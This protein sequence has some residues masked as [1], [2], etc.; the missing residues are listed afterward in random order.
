MK[1]VNTYT[2]FAQPTAIGWLPTI[3]GTIQ[4]VR[5]VIW[6][7]PHGERVIHDAVAK[8][9]A[10]HKQPL[11]KPL[12]EVLN[13]IARIVSEGEATT[14]PCTSAKE[15]LGL[16]AV[17]MQFTMYLPSIKCYFR[18]DYR[19]IEVLYQAITTQGAK[20]P[21]GLDDQLR[22]ALKI[23][24]TL[25]EALW[26]LLTASRLYARWYDGEAFTHFPAVSQ[27]KAKRLMSTWSTA[28]AAL[29]PWSATSPQ[30]PSGDMYYVW[31]HVFAKVLYG[32]MSPWWALDAYCYRAALH[33]GTWLNHTIAHRVSPQS[34]NSNHTVAARYGNAVGLRIA[35]G[36]REPVRK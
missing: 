11:E 7:P 33:I 26:L 21:V 2:R 31:T 13:S 25:P 12:S 6:T 3:T 14:W 4:A 22:A 28:I 30:D 18:A 5:T 35:L 32:P 23:A 8:T 1:K 9:L 24:G 15:R 19:Q 16:F 36:Y 27:T 20:H 29:K 17:M 34:I 10:S